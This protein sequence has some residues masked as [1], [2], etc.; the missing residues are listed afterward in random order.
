MMG[1]MHG[2]GVMK[3]VDGSSYEGEVQNDMKHGRGIMK[4]ADGDVYDGE[5]FD[6]LKHGRCLMRCGIA[7]LQYGRSRNYEVHQR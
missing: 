3:G 6:D 7:V 1:K 2:R 5:W 4:Y